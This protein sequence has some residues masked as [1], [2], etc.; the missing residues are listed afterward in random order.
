MTTPSPESSYE[1][2]GEVSRSSLSDD[3]YCFSDYDL[4]MVQDA[5]RNPHASEFQDRFDYT[6]QLKTDE[7]QDDDTSDNDNNDS[8]QVCL[9]TEHSEKPPSVLPST[10]LSSSSSSTIDEDDDDDDT[11]IDTAITSPTASKHHHLSLSSVVSEGLNRKPVLTQ[12]SPQPI[13][14]TNIKNQRKRSSTLSALSS[15]TIKTHPYRRPQQLALKE[16]VTNNLTQ[17]KETSSTDMYDWEFWATV[18]HQFDTVNQQQHQILRDHICIGMPP[19]LRGMLWQIFSKS[20]HNSDTI[21]LEYRELLKRVSPHEKIIQRDLARTFPTHA[22]F[23]KRDGGGQEMLF[24]VIKAYSLFDPQVGYCQGLPFVV[25]CLLLHMPD[26]AAFCVLTNLMNDYKMRAF[27]TP[28]MELLHE[29]M[30]Q[31]DELLL[32]H[33]PQ[34]HRHLEAQGVRPTMYASQWFM[35]LFAYRCPLELVFRILDMVFIEGTCIILNVALALMKKNQSTLLS[36]EFEGLLGFL[37]SNVF[38]VYQDDASELVKDSYQFNILPREL[39]KLSKR[40]TIKAAQEAKVQDKEDHLRQENY[41]LS[42][43]AKK[44]EKSYKSLEKEHEELARQVIESK[45]AMAS[46]NDE[47]Q[48]LRHEVT[49]LDQRIRQTKHEGELCKQDEFNR[50]ANENTQLVQKNA[51]LED[52]LAEVESTLIE[53]KM[54]YAQSENEYEQMKKTL[55]QIKKISS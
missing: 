15:S 43:R 20:R 41:E 11:D 25:G 45:M 31:F 27:F 17:L 13:L 34:V 55:S 50:L 51:Q 44:L 10:S 37:G 6:T 1:S 3:Q 47:N 2:C 7:E 8:S 52:H 48:R 19:S 9:A 28:K 32:T 36:L 40:H 29:R 38:D 14:T 35:T 12:L 53:F 22:F 54:K 26:E 42:Q 16:E 18:I 5:L 30:F 46:A 4:N 23:R 21:E 24:N 39:A 49:L 33:L